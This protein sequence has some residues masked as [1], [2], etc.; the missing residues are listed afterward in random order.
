[1]VNDEY[2]FKLDDEGNFSLRETNGHAEEAERSTCDCCGASFDDDDLRT[3]G[4]NEDARVCESCCD[5]SYTYVENATRWG[6][7][8]V[9]SNDVFESVE[10]DTLTD[11]ARCLDGYT[12]LACG[13]YE[14]QYTQDDN[15]FCDVNGEY[16]HVDDI[17]DG[18]VCLCEGSTHSGEYIDVDD[19]V[20]DI[21]GNYWHEDD[22]GDGVTKVDAGKHEGEYVCTDEVVTC[23]NGT[24]WHTG[25]IDVHIKQSA[26]DPSVYV[27]ITQLEIVEGETE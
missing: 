16:W 4:V 10:G 6:G 23:A 8:F 27:D 19:A 11:S 9:H 22:V 14:G 17:G 24:I 12:H 25:D 15:A 13:Q 26:L 2:F 3:V 21:E 5:D 20:E 7:C 18:V 1:M